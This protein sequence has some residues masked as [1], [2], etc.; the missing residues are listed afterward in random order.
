VPVGDPGV[1]GAGLGGSD[2]SQLGRAEG[3]QDQAAEK[4]RV[5]RP[6]GWSQRAA[7]GPAPGRQPVEGELLEQRRGAPYVDDETP[8]LIGLD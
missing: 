5:Q 4:V 1:P 7:V 6:G 8:E 2:H 3:R